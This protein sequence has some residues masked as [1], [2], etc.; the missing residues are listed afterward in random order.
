MHVVTVELANEHRRFSFKTFFVRRR[1]PLF[2]IPICI[3][4]RAFIIESMRDFV[5]N[6]GADTA[7]IYSCV[8]AK[9]EKWWLEYCGREYDFIHVRCVICIHR[10]WIHVPLGPI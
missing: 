8:S 4:L 7:I 5:R 3:E 9:R 1:P 2:Q 10:L 6:D